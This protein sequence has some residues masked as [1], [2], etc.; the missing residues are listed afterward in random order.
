M[1]D[2]L[3][4]QPEEVK[5]EVKVE[6]PKKPNTFL[7]VLVTILV[8]TLLAVVVG[9]FFFKVNFKGTKE[10]TDTGTGVEVLE[11]GESPEEGESGCAVETCDA[12]A[13]VG[14]EVKNSGWAQFCFPDIKF[15][16]EIPSDLIKFDF[17]G[18]EL[19][20]RWTAAQYSRPEHKFTGFGQYV[21]TVSIQFSPFSTN[22]VVCGGPGCAGM[23]SISIDV[24]KNTSNKTLDEL[25]TAFKNSPTDPDAMDEI[26]GSKTT[27]WGTSVYKY[28]QG[29]VYGDIPGYLLVKNGFVYDVSY[30]LSPSPTAAYTSAEKI[31]E[32]MQFN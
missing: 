5:A 3:K 15:S 10:V 31:I 9:L 8:M 18:T 28:A 30:T 27:K 13:K 25:W 26:N 12:S 24:F 20:S 21:K 2:K 4:T 29:S 11:E 22:G 23:S 16:A 7:A 19:E 1:D 17:S 14:C 32:S 6:T